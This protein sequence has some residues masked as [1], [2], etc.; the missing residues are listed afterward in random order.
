MDGGHGDRRRTLAPVRPKATI[1]GGDGDRA[2]T[3]CTLLLA[4]RGELKVC[5][6][7]RVGGSPV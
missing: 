5:M 4:R 2:C 6:E 1:S 3:L 7:S